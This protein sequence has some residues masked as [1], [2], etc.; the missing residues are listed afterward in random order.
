MHPQ[1]NDSFLR[2]S[3]GNSLKFSKAPTFCLDHSGLFS[4]GSPARLNTPGPGTESLSLCSPRHRTWP[5]A[6]G[7]V[8]PHGRAQ[9]THALTRAYTTHTRTPHTHA[10]RTCTRT[11]TT[12]T[13]QGLMHGLT[14]THSP[15]TLT[16]GFTRTHSPHARTRVHTRTHTHTPHTRTHCLPSRRLRSLSAV[17]TLGRS[18]EEGFAPRRFR[19]QLTTSHAITSYLLQE[20][21]QRFNIIFTRT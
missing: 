9:H 18:R 15:H 14:C 13:A 5:R 6:C 19:S 21:R 10:R 20:C 3:Q 4:A 1:I 8:S 7:T 17:H 11:Y 2:A 12:Y 16:H